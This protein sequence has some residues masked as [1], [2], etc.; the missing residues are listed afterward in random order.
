[1]ITHY[2]NFT[3]LTL[4]LSILFSL[5]TYAGKTDALTIDD[6]L[7]D[8]NL[9]SVD[10]SPDDKYLA[11]VW[12]QGAQYCVLV[13]ELA[14]KNLPIV[15]QMCGDVIRAVQ[16]KWANSERLLVELVTP[17]SVRTAT[18]DRNDKDFD[19]REYSNYRNTISMDIKLK[20]PVH[21]MSDRSNALRYYTGFSNVQNMLFKDS[22]HIL[23]ILPE[24]PSR[25]NMLFKVN[26]NTGKS[27]KIV[28]GSRSTRRF[29]SN[30][31]GEP[32]YRIDYYYRTKKTSIFSYLGNN[33]W[34]KIKVLD[35]KYA[36]NETVILDNMSVNK[37]GEI[38]YLR[39][40]QESG[41]YEL[42]QQN[43]QD[44]EESVLVGLPNQDVFNPI[45]FHSSQN[46]VGY[47]TEVDIVRLHFFDK[48]IQ[49]FYDKIATKFPDQNF[50]INSYD[51]KRK[52][53]LVKSYGPNNPS[54]Y[55]IYDK[56]TDKLLALQTAYQRQ[57]HTLLALP[58]LIDYITR[59]G[60]QL[61]AYGLLPP[62][63]DESKKYPMVV[64]PHGGPHSRDRANYDEF[65]Q[66][67][68][69]RG[70]IVIKPNFRGSTGYGLK[71]EEAGYKQW[72]GLMQDDLTDAV[73][74]MVEQGYA[75]KDK[76]CIVGGSY[77]GYA[78]LMATIKTPD[79]FQCAIS[80]NGVTHLE[81]QIEFDIDEGGKLADE[82][83]VYVEK[84]IGH[85]EN[86]AE[87]L[88]KNSPLFHVDKINA[89]ILLIGSVEDNI[90]PH[91]QTYIMLNELRDKN[92]EHEYL[93]LKEADHHVFSYINHTEE[94]Y[95]KVEGFLK[96]YLQ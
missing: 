3:T 79:L 13:R 26:L 25:R 78:A 84:A 40:N 64:L 53:F 38:I 34:K 16:V 30:E 72:G 50:T 1:M 4:L 6:F 19:I 67:I 73:H 23:M 28:S 76:M 32:L 89:S 9:L 54:T 41:F 71:F 63:F 45:S 66:F 29:V 49:N 43:Q 55:F 39:P 17:F 74:F 22:D 15:G 37:D 95:Q 85:L 70:Y 77:G 57:N 10:I 11:G 2:L 31:E 42:V 82:V 87:L 12:R 24:F 46:I 61:R 7:N 56:S 33:K 65:A 51:L 60:T 36:D 18:R 75:D 5:P 62:D 47:S 44:G 91:N 80:I 83:K 21:L 94:I 58:I 88:M 92:K 20:N 96:K 48:R 68:A 59:D 90:V 93:R 86:D 52:K 8:A 69:T 81:K 27:E 35:T 14:V